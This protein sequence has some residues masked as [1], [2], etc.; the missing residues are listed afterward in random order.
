M[1]PRGCIR[2]GRSGWRSQLSLAA[3][4]GHEAPGYLARM[5]PPR[6]YRSG[7][8]VPLLTRL[9]SCRTIHSRIMRSTGRARPCMASSPPHRENRLPPSGPQFGCPKPPPDRSENA[10]AS[11]PSRQPTPS[12]GC[13]A[14]A[15]SPGAERDIRS[16]GF[17][18]ATLARRGRVRFGQRSQICCRLLDTRAQGRY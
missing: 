2:D 17:T 1:H 15:P 11:A 5:G 6:V 12:G 13:A 18:A 14:P 8:V 10:W 3:I 4:I 7:P 16:C 9:R